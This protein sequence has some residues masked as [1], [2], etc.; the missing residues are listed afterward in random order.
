EI[1]KAHPDVFNILLQVMEDGRL[2]DSQ[3]RVVDFRNAVIIMTSNVGAQMI[4]EDRMGLRRAG[5]KD[6]PNEKQH[7]EMKKRVMEELK[8]TFRPEFL[9]RVDEIVFFH[10]L[11][12]AEIRQIVD[13][14][15]GRVAAQ[16]RQQGIGL[17]A[18][19]P[20]KDL[21]SK[22]GFDP[23]YGARPLRRAIQRLVEDPLSEDVLLGT[24]HD[25]DTI[26]VDVEGDKL[27]F[28]KSR[29]EIE[30]KEPEPAM[31]VA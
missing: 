1:E 13:L 18:S 22:E 17:E 16:L 25:G 23:T 2:T 6:E 28:A 15:L 11:T 26:L 14:M 7:E 3:G 10:A 21:L 8:R 27:V 20:A 12:T 4:R 29:V 19:E 9:N 5:G 31:P 24:F 30:T